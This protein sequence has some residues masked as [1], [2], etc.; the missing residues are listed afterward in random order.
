MTSSSSP[1][2]HDAPAPLSRRGFMGGAASLSSIP[3]LSHAARAD[4]KDGKQQP[5]PPDDDPAHYRPVFFSAEEYLFL[6]HACERIFPQDENGPGAQ[7]LGVPRFIDRQMTTPYGRGDLWYM[8]APFVNGP[9]ELGY[10]LP[11]SPQD[12]YRGAITPINT[13]CLM[14]HDAVF[15]ALSPQ[16]QDEVLHALEDNRLHLNDIPG[17]AFFEQLRT[18]TLEGA[19]SDPAY[20]GNHNMAGWKMMDFPGARADFMDWINQ[21]GAR[22]P[23]GPVGMPPKPD[24]YSASFQNEEG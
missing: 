21:D 10:Q 3:L 23:L 18:N 11:Y 16:W 13:H 15:A 17:A 24:P 2:S 22:Y 9:P 14:L 19:F 6:C 8:K 4:E 20:G 7:A 12:L 1:P 5:A